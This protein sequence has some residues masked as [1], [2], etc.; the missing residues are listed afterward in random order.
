MILAAAL[1]LAMQTAPD[2]LA[3]PPDSTFEKGPVRVIARVEG[4]AELRIDGKPV[5]AESPAEGMLTVEVDASPGDHEVSIGTGDKQQKVR[6]R[7]GAPD[8]T[9][10]A[11]RAHPPVAN[12]ATCHAV[13][14]GVWAL[15]R[16][17]L[18]TLCTQCHDKEAFPKSHVHIPG[19]VAD[20]QMC[21]NPHGGTAKALLT[22]SKEKACKQ[23]HN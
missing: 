14:N 16:A 21:H 3:P 19:V 15:Q 23:C 18:V 7:I 8:G 11:F 5:A 17:S 4:K 12:C 6:F 22:M 10:A 1:F 13:K 2:I 9:F 20:C